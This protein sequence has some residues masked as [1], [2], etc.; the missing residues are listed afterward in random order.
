MPL[1]EQTPH[2]SANRS[3]AI[4]NINTYTLSLLNQSF[5]KLANHL[6]PLFST[7]S[8]LTKF[9]VSQVPKCHLNAIP[10]NRSSTICSSPFLTLPILHPYKNH[11]HHHHHFS[12]LRYQNQ[13]TLLALKVLDGLWNLVLLPSCARNYRRLYSQTLSIASSRKWKSTFR[14]SFD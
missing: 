10:I 12:C 7:V 3:L 4:A 5:F 6:Q 9:G 8:H 11:L 14:H 1:I 2:V 13:I